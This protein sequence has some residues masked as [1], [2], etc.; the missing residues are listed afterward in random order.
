MLDRRLGGRQ[1]A[2]EGRGHRDHRQRAGGSCRLAGGAGRQGRGGQGHGV[3]DQRAA[4][5]RAQREERVTGPL[6]LPGVRELLRRGLPGDRR[7]D[8]VQAGGLRA[9][10][11]DRRGRARRP[12]V[13]DGGVHRP[14]DVRPQLQRLVRRGQGG[15]V[16]GPVGRHLERRGARIE[17][18]RSA[19]RPGGLGAQPVEHQ[20][21]GPHR[22][23]AGRALRHR[24]HEPL[25]VRGQP[26]HVQ[27]RP[28]V[29]RAAHGAAGLRG[30]GVGGA[31]DGVLRAG[32]QRQGQQFVVVGQ[33]D[34][35]R[36][37]VR[38]EDPQGA[39]GVGPVTEVVAAAVVPQPCRDSS[40]ARAARRPSTAVSIRGIRPE[41]AACTR[42][43]TAARARGALR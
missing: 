7:V 13:R 5:G 18:H 37:D 6:Q 29:D 20:Q 38:A 34:P 40:S 15:G 12:V 11:D 35:L 10:P 4:A 32:Q 33:R 28:P 43:G 23:A 41:T 9:G 2:L 39:A 42:P 26:R 25:R 19:Q 24:G 30:C 1:Q 36:G 16:T 22:A 14:H 8:L 31:G 27:C 3:E 21:R 17:Q